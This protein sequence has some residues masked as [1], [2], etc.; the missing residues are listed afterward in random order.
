MT[1]V[2]LLVHMSKLIHFEQKSHEISKYHVITY[3]K[4]E[5]VGNN[6]LFS[7]PEKSAYESKP[8]QSRNSQASHAERTPKLF[9][10]EI[11]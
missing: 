10:F 2:H 7:A 3:K 4:Q 5:H 9:Q 8:F 11:D 6:A 1:K